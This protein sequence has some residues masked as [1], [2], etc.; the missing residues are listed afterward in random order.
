M[1]A[2][3]LGTSDTTCVGSGAG[4]GAGSVPGP[5][6]ENPSSSSCWGGAGGAD[7]VALPVEPPV[8]ER[9]LLRTCRRRVGGPVSKHTGQKEKPVHLVQ[10]RNARERRRVQAVNVAFSRLSKVVPLETRGKRISKVKTLH[11]AIEYIDQLRR[12]LAADDLSR[13]HVTGSAPLESGGDKEN[14]WCAPLQVYADLP[15]QQHVY[16]M[17]YTIMTGFTPDQ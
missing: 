1:F 17:Q 7:G 8:R 15:P 6:R 13:G 10:R 12:L 4:V 5:V 3:G 14:A 11:K 2:G 9:K 16:N